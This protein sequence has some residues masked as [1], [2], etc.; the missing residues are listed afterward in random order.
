MVSRAFASENAFI[1]RLIQGLVANK[2]VTHYFGFI[3]NSRWTTKG[4]VT[5][6]RGEE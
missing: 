3:Q 6:T 1:V 5:E 2:T 4:E